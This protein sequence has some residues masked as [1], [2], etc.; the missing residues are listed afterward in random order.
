MRVEGLDPQLTQYPVEL[1][2]G[3]PIY[4]RMTLQ[5]PSPQLPGVSATTMCGDG[6]YIGFCQTHPP[7]PKI[8]KR[9]DGFGLGRCGFSV[10]YFRRSA[11]GFE[12]EQSRI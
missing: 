10:E 7:P 12:I 3:T 6:L 2:Y 4:S 11:R 9:V 5:Y 8:S 1:Y